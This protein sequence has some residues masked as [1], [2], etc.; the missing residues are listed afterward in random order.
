M[1]KFVV[2]LA[3]GL[4]LWLFWRQRATFIDDAKPAA[5]PFDESSA[6]CLTDTDRAYS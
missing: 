4:A 5:Q 3:L 1:I 2:P 6:T